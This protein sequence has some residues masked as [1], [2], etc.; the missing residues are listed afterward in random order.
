MRSF[1]DMQNTCTSVY[2][3]GYFIYKDKR[4]G[5]FFKCNDKSS[6]CGA[7]HI[8]PCV[9]AV[10]LCG[11]MWGAHHNIIVLCMSWKASHKINRLNWFTIVFRNFYMWHCVKLD[12]RIIF[13]ILKNFPGITNQ[14]SVNKAF[15]AFQNKAAVGK[16]FWQFFEPTC[17]NARWAHMHHFASVTKITGH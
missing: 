2:F 3:E 11:F 10:I 17:A 15:V 9:H 7:L 1:R 16:W 6:C 8:S 4:G 13:M 14:C 5:D 12:F